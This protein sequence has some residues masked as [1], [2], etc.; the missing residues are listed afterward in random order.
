MFVAINYI[1]CR[2]DY[3][4]RFEELFKSRAKAID[5]LHGFL[6]M[7]VCRP[8]KTGDSYLVISQWEDEKSFQA[9]TKSPEFWEG[10]RRGFEDVKR[11][12]EAGE[13]PPIVSTFRTYEV[14][15]K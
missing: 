3:R 8:Q 11:A 13:E 7:T 14:I 2:D 9:W 10:H 5:R 1:T 4:V 6:G 12:K 15:A